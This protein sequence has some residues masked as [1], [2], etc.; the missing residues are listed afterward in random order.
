MGEV[1][2]TAGAGAGGLR[3]R[4]LYRAEKEAWGE[5]LYALRVFPTLPD[6]T[7]TSYPPT[8]VHVDG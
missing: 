7:L 1:V 8:P 4:E 3:C 2:D 5:S 6:S